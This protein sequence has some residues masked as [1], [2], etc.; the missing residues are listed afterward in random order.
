MTK[1]F[2]FLGLKFGIMKP[3][4]RI[5]YKLYKLYKACSISAEVRS[6]L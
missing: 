4:L 6:N 3:F 2:A 1:Q 5:N